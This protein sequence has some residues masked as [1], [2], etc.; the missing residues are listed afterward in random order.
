MQQRFAAADGDDGGA[1]TGEQVEPL[2]SRLEGTGFETSS[3]SLQ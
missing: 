3:N 1:Q 2:A